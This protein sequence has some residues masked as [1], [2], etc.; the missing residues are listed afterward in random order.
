MDSYFFSRTRI[1]FS[2]TAVMF[3]VLTCWLGRRSRLTP[4]QI[5][6]SW[7]LRIGLCLERLA[8]GEYLVPASRSIDAVN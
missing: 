6:D 8:G 4:L 7:S 3:S 2:L 5:N 1:F